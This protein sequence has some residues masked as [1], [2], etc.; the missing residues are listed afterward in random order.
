MG[1]PLWPRTMTAARTGAS[2]RHFSALDHFEELEGDPRAALTV[3]GND[4]Q[5]VPSK[6]KNQFRG[7]WSPAVHRR[8]PGEP[9]SLATIVGTLRQGHPRI[10]YRI[11]T[12]RRNT[13]RRRA[14]R[15]EGGISYPPRANRVLGQGRSRCAGQSRSPRVFHRRKPDVAER[16]SRGRHAVRPARSHPVPT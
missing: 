12:Y 10:E 1:S 4:L 2:G 3:E 16:A 14:I 5:H 15:R 11:Y 8:F 9:A 13:G 7:H 6:T